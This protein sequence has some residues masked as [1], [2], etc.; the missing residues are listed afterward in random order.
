MPL[1]RPVFRRHWWD[2]WLHA[3]PAA[4]LAIFLVPIIVG[5]I[6][7]WIPAFGYL[8]A[9]GG[10]TLT[11]D[12]WRR[13]FEAPGLGGAVRLTLLTGIV[14]TLLSLGATVAILAA[15]HGTRV[16]RAIRRSLAPLLA[17]PHAALA[18]GLAFLLT[19][20]G[21][22]ARALSPWATGWDRPPDLLVVQDPHGIALIAGLAI[23]ATAYRL[24]MSLAALQQI[25]VHDDMTVAGSLGY[26]PFAAWLK[27]VLPQLYPQIRLPIFAV[28]AYALSV[29]DMAMILGPSTP[30]TLAPLILRWTADTDLA[31]R[32]VAAAGACLQIVAVIAAWAAGERAI[33]VC[34]RPWLSAGGRGGRLWVPRVLSGIAAATMVLL[35][36]GAIAGMAVWSM[37]SRWR[38]PDPLPTDW[39]VTNWSNALPTLGASASTTLVVAVV[40][41]LIALTLVIGCLEHEQRHHVR[42]TNRAMWLLYTPLLVPQIGFLF[43]LQVVLVSLD[44][45]G[46]WAALIWSHLLFVLPYIFLALSDPWRA[47]DER[48]QRTA[49]CLGA[50][51]ARAFWAIKLPML[52]RPVLMAA[53]VGFAVSVAQYLPTVFAGAGRLT[54]L[55]TEAVALASGADRRVIGVYAFAQATLPAVIFCSALI[56]P[57]WLYRHR[58]GM[59]R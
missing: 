33:I 16:E 14:S 20:S 27:V 37:A 6:A 13:L 31:M 56:L 15:W 10:T 24:L 57:A 19:P 12:P 48:Y 30:P 52:L 4:T 53:A 7:T 42:P 44:L 17:V 22:I 45:D 9:L 28:L 34:L 26:R 5:L 41:T 18:I 11:F 43:G 59:R 25:R 1:I 51:P 55:T 49:A 50:S 40:A 29:V 3:A 39:R 2:T 8:P 32:F 47:L 36:A 23:T 35:A 54:T 58:R 46:G 21:W 38:W